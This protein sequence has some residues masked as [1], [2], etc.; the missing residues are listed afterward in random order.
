MY[1]HRPQDLQVNIVIEF[2]L[3]T[4]EP[5]RNNNNNNNTYNHEQTSDMPPHVREF[6]YFLHWR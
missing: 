1:V 5:K 4:G 6:D 2:I 3:S